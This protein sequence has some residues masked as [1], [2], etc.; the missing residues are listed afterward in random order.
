MAT[1]AYDDDDAELVNVLR[2]IHANSEQ[3]WV[4]VVETDADNY[5]AVAVDIDPREYEAVAAEEIAH[6]PT[7]TGA[8]KRAEQWA[9]EHSKGVAGDSKSGGHLTRLVSK[10]ADAGESLAENQQQQQQQNQQQ[11][12]ED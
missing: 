1:H 10:V 4:L 12:T 6:S 2:R 11:Q 8:N 9:A 3:T 5:A 7:A